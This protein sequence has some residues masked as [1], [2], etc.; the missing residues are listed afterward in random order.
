VSQRPLELGADV[1]IHSATKYLNGHGDAL[2]GAVLGKHDFVSEV[3]ERGV[4]HLG[5]CISPF[6]AW[7]IMRGI[8]TL[9]LRIEK[10]E[11]NALE[12]ARFLESHRRVAQVRYPGLPSHPQHEVAKKQMTGFSGM[13]NF[14]LDCELL[15]NLEFLK[16]LELVTHAVSLGHDQSLLMYIPTAFFLQDMV[17]LSEKKEMKYWSLMGDGVFRFSVGIENQDDIIEDLS[18]ALDSL[19]A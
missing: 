12:V 4:V 7:L 17:K 9:P 5:A 2:G 16:R 1:V 6:N 15:E 19:G 10:H 18:R 11:A 8:T 13:M 14:S 3:R